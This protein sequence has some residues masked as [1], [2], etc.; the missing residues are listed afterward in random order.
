[1]NT[2]YLQELIMD[3]LLSNF[4]MPVLPAFDP[5]I[6]ALAHLRTDTVSAVFGFISRVRMLLWWL[7]VI[8]LSVYAI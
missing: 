8:W 2:K 6:I 1:M 4:C 5:R 3:S 7:N